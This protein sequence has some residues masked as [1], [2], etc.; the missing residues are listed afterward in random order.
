MASPANEFCYDARLRSEAHLDVRFAAV[1]SGVYITFQKFNN[2]VE[3][4]A[5]KV[6]PA[7]R[8]VHRG[9]HLWRLDR[10]ALSTARTRITRQDLC[11]LTMSGRRRGFWLRGLN[12][13]AGRIDPE[14]EE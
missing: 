3:L 5:I 2:I 13:P 1:R 7:R 8:T 14:G 6:N 12:D 4:V 9:P 10:R 11:V